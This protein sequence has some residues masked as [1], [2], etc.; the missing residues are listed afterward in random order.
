MTTELRPI[1]D[2]LLLKGFL[3]NKNEK[4]TRREA[5]LQEGQHHTQPR[6]SPSGNSVGVEPVEHAMQGTGQGSARGRREGESG[7]ARR[8]GFKP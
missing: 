8:G 2:N 5:K 1:D 6:S 4:Q 3:H 7:G